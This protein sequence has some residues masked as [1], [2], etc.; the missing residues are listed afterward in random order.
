MKR[1]QLHK[2]QADVSVPRWMVGLSLV[3]GSVVVLGTFM[4]V[5]WYNTPAAGRMSVGARPDVT[6]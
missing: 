4:S 5:F 3:V 2:K 1:S 6:I